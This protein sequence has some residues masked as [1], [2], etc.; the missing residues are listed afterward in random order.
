MMPPTSAHN[1]PGSDAAPNSPTVTKR[2]AFQ[3][4]LVDSQFVLTSLWRKFK[5]RKENRG[6]A[7]PAKYYRGAASLPVSDSTP[8]IGHL[9]DIIRGLREKPEAPAIPIT[10]QPSDVPDLW[11]DFK[12]RKWSWVNGVL[13]TIAIIAAVV[14]P[15]MIME[16]RSPALQQAQVVPITLS[17]YLPQLPPAA[18][19]SGGGGGGGDRTPTPPSKGSPPVFAKVQL[20][21]PAAKIKIPKPQLPVDPTLLG[22]PNLKVTTAYN[23]FGN[24]TS[25]PGPP[26]NGPGDGG[27]IGTGS[28]GGVGS[29]NG[30][31]LGPG[32]GAGTG[33]GVY[34]LGGGV[35]TPIAIYSPDPPYTE[36]A[37]E[38]KFQGDVVLSIVVL[39]DGSVADVQIVKPLGLGLDQSAVKAVKTWKFK[40]GTRNGVPVAVQMMIDVTFHL[41]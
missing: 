1:Q 11:E 16:R 28:G 3:G 39:A 30:A 32:S 29:G 40:P 7:I 8:L 13:V 12:P 18:K 38:A 26:S 9:L 10:S 19:H 35:S 27:G 25:V 2:P 4:N 6:I 34:Q 5:E 22:P 21:P 37:R 15:Y 24:P 20:A 33:G 36:Q 17:P 23:V 41:L 14:L 31:G